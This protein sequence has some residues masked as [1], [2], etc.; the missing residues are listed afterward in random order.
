[1]Q[2]SVH[3]D[4]IALRDELLEILNTAG[5]NFLCGGLRQGSVVIVEKFFGVE[6]LEAL[7]NTVANATSTNGANNF[8]LEIKCITGYARRRILK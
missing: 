6:G 4:N 8:A 2:R 1:M 3:S 5:I 7:E